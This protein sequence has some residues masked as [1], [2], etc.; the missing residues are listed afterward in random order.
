ME[1][2]GYELLAL[3]WFMEHLAAERHSLAAASG[4]EGGVEAPPLELASLDLQPSWEPYLA[5]LSQT[6]GGASDE[7]GAAGGGARARARRATYGFGQ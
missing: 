4:A 3:E 6:E 7:A 2:T 5:C 1:N